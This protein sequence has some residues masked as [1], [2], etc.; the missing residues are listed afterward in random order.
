MDFSIAW[1]N[2]LQSFIEKFKIVEQID[3]DLAKSI[4]GCTWIKNVQIIFSTFCIKFFYDKGED[5]T[6]GDR[7]HGFTTD[8]NSAFGSHQ[9]LER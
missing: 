6:Y 4:K 9:R 5:L 1:H 2:H 8:D 7:D 3:K